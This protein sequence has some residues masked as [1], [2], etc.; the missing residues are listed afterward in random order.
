MAHLIA[1]SASLVLFF[2]FVGLTALE[3]KR[4][5]RLLSS[6]REKLD[7]V[8]TR[9]AHT[10]ASVDPLDLLVRGARVVFAHVIHDIANVLWAVA[11]M[12]ERTLAGVVYRLRHLRK[13]D[14]RTETNSS[15]V[16]SISFHKRTLR[17]PEGSSEGQTTPNEVQ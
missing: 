15:F 13:S 12:L 14:E 5:T 17:S 8:A 4:G 2:G 7:R 11:R 16:R 6:S 9:T 3:K 10:L 1:I